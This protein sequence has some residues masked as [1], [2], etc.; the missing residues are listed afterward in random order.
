MHS[1]VATAIA[2]VA[3]LA[4]VGC[5]DNAGATQFAP[6]SSESLYFSYPLNEQ[7]Q[8]SPHAPLALRFNGQVDARKQNFQLVDSSGAEVPM[9][10]AVA[11]DRQG[12]VLRPLA[13]LA[14]AENHVLTLRNLTVDQR[15][16]NF[17]DGELRFTTRAAFDGALSNQVTA[18]QFEVE[19]LFPDDGLFKSMD[20]T[21]FRLRT[22]QPIDR[23]SVTYGE[24][25]SLTRNGELVDALLLVSGSAITVDPLEDMT[26]GDTYTLEVAGLRNQRGDEITRYSHST[27]PQDTTSPTTGERAV[28]VTEAPAADDCMAPSGSSISVL[29]GEGINCVPVNS[30]LLQD[31]TVSGLSGDILGELAFGPNF[32]DVIPLRVKRGGVLNGAALDILVG[33]DVDVGWDSGDVL[34]EV[35]SDASGYLFPN[36]NSD[37]DDAPKHLRL[38]MDVAFSTRDARANGAFT[39]NLMHLELVGEGL[40]AD[41]MLEVNAITVAEP[42]VLGVENA[43]GVLSF[44]MRSYRDQENAP[45]P[46]IDTTGPFIPELN[47]DLSWQPGR[48]PE[49]VKPGEPIVVHFNEVLDPL[50]IAR[51]FAEGGFM[52]SRDGQQQPF[53]W[54]MDGTALVVNPESPLAFSSDYSL[55]LNAQITDLAG[56]PLQQDYVLEFTMPHYAQGAGVV[57]RAPF[58][59][60]NY[61]GFPCHID[62]SS[63]DIANDI[64]GHCSTFHNDTPHD[65]LPIDPLPANRNI[66]IRFSQN[67][68]A[69]SLHSGFSVVNEDSGETVQGLLEVSARDLTFTPMVPWQEGVLYSY[70]LTSNQGSGC[71]GICSQQGLPLQTAM[72]LG[73]PP[74]QGGPSM[75]VLFRGAP[76]ATTIFQPLSNLPRLDVNTNLVVDSAEMAAGLNNGLARGEGYR[77]ADEQAQGGSIPQNSV[78]LR[79][80]GKGAS[81]NLLSGANIGCGFE[82][83]NNADKPLQCDD[84]KLL[85]LTAELN[86]ELLDFDPDA[87]DLDNTP[88]GVPVVIYPAHALLGNLNAVALLGLA[89]DD[90]APCIPIPL[91]GGLL[92][93]VLAPVTDLL[94]VPV[95]VDTGPN[96]MR[97]RYVD[98]KPPVGI[99]NQQFDSAG[100]PIPWFS[101]TLDLLFDAPELVVL[102]GLADHNVKNL[103]IADVKLEGPVEFLPDGRLFL[104]LL[105]RNSLNVSMEIDALGLGAGSVNLEIPAG[106][107]NLSYQSISIK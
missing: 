100:Q 43:H 36:P 103:V 91:L 58:I 102:G 41:G 64:Q 80:I 24:T 33:G 88:G 15:P 54:H 48:Q 96:V 46:R 35:I 82:N 49:R 95:E 53:S 78:F 30:T 5:D 21:S 61:P 66:A 16:T 98:G 52:L 39:Q 104:S 93:D 105:N 26:P 12:V 86:A 18:D 57:A 72:L 4:L 77:F 74:E 1:K 75:T 67:M 70:T 31:K 37:A 7:Q 87:L 62:R 106:G 10:L 20:F 19:S 55:Q 92:C 50:S 83:I 63:A 101:V 76:A 27:V 2:L 89:S 14:T 22:T 34:V 69:D 44:Q 71:D 84:K 29:T 60:T 107:I 65:L 81:G 25:I 90:D 51:A 8:V 59:T 38:F 9:S 94:Q 97:V 47:G 42:K 32:P 79:P 45:G 85:Y 11:S 17:R 23:R 68:D 13:P 28:L 40:I 73:L 56:N 3:S 99:I 6:I